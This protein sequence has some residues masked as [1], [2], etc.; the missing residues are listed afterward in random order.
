MNGKFL[1]V[2][3]FS[4]IIFGIF[5]YSVLMTSPHSELTEKALTQAFNEGYQTAVCEVH[6]MQLGKD[7]SECRK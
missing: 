6:R 1:H 4:S 2:I 7:I 5:V 3:I